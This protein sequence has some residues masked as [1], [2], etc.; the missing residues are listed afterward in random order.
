MASYDFIDTTGV[1]IADT[2][3]TLAAVQNEWRT[4]FG[5]DLI[6]TANT[7]QGVLITAEALA[8][9]A[10]LRNNAAVA[11]QI[12]PNLAGGV[13]LDAIWALTGGGRRRA[14]SSLI[15]VVN[16]TGVPG[17]T[18]P[19]GSQASVGIGGALFESVG[20][21][22]FD[23]GGLAAIAFQSF[24]LGP[25][26]AP[27]AALNTIVTG[28]LGWET[29]TN[30]G[31][32]VLGLSD[33]SDVAARSRRRNT[34]ALQGVALNEAIVS[35]LYD[36][37]GVKSLAYRE[38]YTTAPIVIEGVT[39]AANSIYACV[40]GGTDIDVATSLVLNKSLGCG[41]TGA[42][43]PINVLDPA[44]GQLYPVH[45]A[46]PTAIPI[47]MTVTVKSGSA[48][49]D[50]Q[51]SVRQA[52][53][54][55]AAGL[56]TGEAGFTVGTDVSAFELSAAINAEAIDLFVTNFLIDIAPAPTTS[57]TIV[58]TIAEI[59]TIVAGNIAV[60]VV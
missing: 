4:A 35:A 48:V 20:D 24:D 47:F 22:T 54:D 30:P 37:D 56:L 2:G 16:L 5:A 15:G 55:Y 23:A 42:V 17:V 28:V 51:Q 19:A 12:N 38:N 11:N 27:V 18:V 31:A 49:A 33:E 26:A 39:I 52:I 10:V 8:R 21:V 14:T 50:P 43:G 34:L 7:P 45:F 57:D 44:S 59:A 36:T 41:W 60:N 29:V 58:I 53:L 6:V 40:D 25:V 32:A 3:D 46:R 9:D 13:F 1:I